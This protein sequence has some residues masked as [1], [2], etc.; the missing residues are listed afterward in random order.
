MCH[1][2]NNVFGM[3]RGNK[4]IPVYSRSIQTISNILLITID[5]FIDAKL[6]SRDLDL[7]VN[8]KKQKRKVIPSTRKV[9][10]PQKYLYGNNFFP[11]HIE[12]EKA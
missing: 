9:F 5:Y 12:K 6:F 10:T 11:F 7:F 8:K 1:K 3:Y 2:V 4:L